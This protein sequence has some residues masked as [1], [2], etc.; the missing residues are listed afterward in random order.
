MPDTVPGSRE[1]LFLYL[2]QLAGRSIRT[3]AELESYLKEL[4]AREVPAQAK[5]QEQR[6]ATV[7]HALLGV[8]LLIA[9]LQYYLIDVYVQ[10]LALQ[11]LQVFNPVQPVLHHSALELLR[12]FC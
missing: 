7:K 10:I 2:D 11:R 1:E 8:G 12:L 6:W 9:V 5:P 3:R 4:K